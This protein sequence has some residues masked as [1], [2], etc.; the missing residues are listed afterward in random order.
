M[1]WPTLMRKSHNTSIKPSLAKCL[2][3]PFANWVLPHLAPERYCSAQKAAQIAFA[4]RVV[5]KRRAGALRSVFDFEDFVPVVGL[6]VEQLRGQLLSSQQ[7]PLSQ[8]GGVFT[9]K[10]AER[11]TEFLEKQDSQLA[12]TISR[13]RSRHLVKPAGS[14]ETIF[15]QRDAT[16]M[17]FRMAGLRNAI[18]DPDAGSWKINELQKTYLTERPREDVGIIADACSFLGWKQQTT[19]GFGLATFSDGSGSSLTIININRQPSETLTG[20]DLVYYHMQR[21]SFVHVQY[22]RMIR[23]P[24]SHPANSWAYG[25][26]RHFSNQLDALL[27]LDGAATVMSAAADYRLSAETGY[28]KFTM[29]EHYGPGD[30]ALVP[31]QYMSASL[32]DSV[33]RARGGRIKSLRSDD[34]TIPYLT[35][36]LFADLVGYGLIGTR[37]VDPPEMQRLFAELAKPK[38]SLVLGIHSEQS[39]V[40]RSRERDAFQ[41]DETSGIDALFGKHPVSEH[42]PGLEMLG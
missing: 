30:A 19:D 11:V 26:D 2:T 29:M 17:L 12:A 25:E 41:L 10:A 28:F 16:A 36:T 14:S 35:N 5:R 13:W 22:K 24:G 23:L 38:Q 6:S 4:A 37:G 32:L 21:N 15:E 7:G 9:D 42:L 18:M 34:G 31:G 40:R 1:A 20:G 27:S 33:R 3:S 8:P 39:H